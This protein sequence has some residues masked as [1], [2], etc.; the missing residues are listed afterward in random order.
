MSKK[1]QELGPKT[2]GVTSTTLWMSPISEE[3]EKFLKTYKEDKLKARIIFFHRREDY[4]GNDYH[5][6]SAGGGF[7]SERLML[8]ERPNGDFSIVLFHI[9]WGLSI[10]NKMYK[11]QSA[12]ASVSYKKADNKF[13]LIMRRKGKRG[14]LPL[15][16]AN[17]GAAFGMR[18]EAVKDKMQEKFGWLRFIREKN[19]L[20]N[21]AFNTI[22]KKKLFSYEAA[23]RHMYKTP[24]PVAQK[25]H[26]VKSGNSNI[27]HTLGSKGF[28]AFLRHMSNIENISDE[29][30]KST[31]FWDT[32]R[33]ARILDRKV[34]CSWSDTRMRN[35]HDTWAKEITSVLLN[36]NDR[37]MKVH[38]LFMKFQELS[39]YQL[40]TSTREM[41]L[42]GMVNQH[43]VASYV[44]KVDQGRCAIFH[45]NHGSALDYGYT[46][47]V[48]R[49]VDAHG[50]PELAMLQ[51]RGLRNCDAPSELRDEVKSKLDKFNEILKEKFANGEDLANAGEE[52]MTSLNKLFANELDDANLPF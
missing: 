13:W 1:E 24:Y 26:E 16:Y 29:Q 50:C 49:N 20:M 37:Q 27:M 12:V 6:T 31:I 3:F 52:E 23:L 34:N 28:D 9:K 15:T 35:E 25:L 41:S 44:S 2:E 33:M 10:T 45:L 30:V 43:C 47:E 38:K 5:V 18:A 40:L 17:L 48:V 51:C 22:V 39:N 19:V 46:L 21:V 7:S 11:S 14:L 42:E 36:V 8:F 4:G 32:V